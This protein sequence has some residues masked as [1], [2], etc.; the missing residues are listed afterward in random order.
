M[1]D[2][3]SDQITLAPG[4]PLEYSFPGETRFFLLENKGFEPIEIFLKDK[5]GFNLDPV[6]LKR[7]ESQQFEIHTDAIK[8]KSQTKTYL[9]VLAVIGVEDSKDG[10]FVRFDK[11]SP[12]P[13]ILKQLQSGQLI[14][15]VCISIIEAYESGFDLM[16]GFPADTDEIVTLN[17]V[18]CSKIANYEFYPYRISEGTETLTL[19]FS[20]TSLSGKGIV[21][22]EE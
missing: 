19:Y 21:F 5:T 9:E 10:F 14:K 4:V 7:H 16:L 8:V 22:V 20:G 13:L 6:V 11:D 15:I 3:F 17:Q 12:N 2:V 18:K 1:D